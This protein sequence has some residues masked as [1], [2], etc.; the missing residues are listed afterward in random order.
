ME[1]VPSS[2]IV[3]LSLDLLSDSPLSIA[4]ASFENP[5]IP[6][7]LLPNKQTQGEAAQEKTDQVDKIV[8]E[9]ADIANGIR[10][11]K[12]K[13]TKIFQYDMKVA[14]ANKHGLSEDVIETEGF[15][16]IWSG[17]LGDSNDLSLEDIAPNRIPIFTS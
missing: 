10:E 9:A 16:K 17:V 7:S 15:K 4:S 8:S 1:T 13:V 14:F 11:R 6:Q 3:A 5:S 2:L 12:E